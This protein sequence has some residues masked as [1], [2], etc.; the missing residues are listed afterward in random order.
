M[1]SLNRRVPRLSNGQSRRAVVFQNL[2]I[3]LM[4]IL[5]AGAT[6][7]WRDR[8]ADEIIKKQEAYS[9]SLRQTIM[10]L[11]QQL[12]NEKI[13]NNSANRAV[14]G[15]MSGAPIESTVGH[16]SK[17]I[18]SGDLSALPQYMAT[19][20][21]IIEVE[22]G[23]VSSYNP[24]MAANKIAKFTSN[25]SSYYNYDFDLSPELLAGYRAGEYGRYLPSTAMIGKS[26]DGRILSLAFDCN[27]KISIVLMT[28][29]ENLIK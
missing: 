28:R 26:G 24:T 2:Y 22:S 3:F 25:N 16:I 19:N 20:V 27:N 8:R 4:I 21:S 12:L 23:A 11:N 13:I 18:N 29:N 15:D 10:V 14:C 5:I 7:W 6:Y 1:F 9:S 17:I